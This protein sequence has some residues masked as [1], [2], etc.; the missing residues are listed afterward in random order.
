MQRTAG[1]PLDSKRTLGTATLRASFIAA[2]QAVRRG[3]YRYG[4]K[5]LNRPADVD[6][7]L[8]RASDGKLTW[9]VKAAVENGS[10][11]ARSCSLGNRLEHDR[12]AVHCVN[13]ALA[14]QW[15]LLD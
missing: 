14:M 10:A 1:A 11:L 3:R 8:F 2:A 7:V 13:P 6:G 5:Q 15:L 9:Q 4:G 12:A